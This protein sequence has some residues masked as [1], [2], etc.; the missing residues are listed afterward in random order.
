[1]R[2]SLPNPWRRD[3]SAQRTNHVLKGT[4]DP[5][6]KYHQG[7]PIT[8]NENKQRGQI[9]FVSSPDAAMWLSIKVC[10]SSKCWIGDTSHEVLNYEHWPC[11]WSVV[12][13]N[14]PFLFWLYQNVLTIISDANAES[15]AVVVVETC[16]RLVFLFCY[17]R[18][19]NM[20][21]HYLFFTG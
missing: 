8:I 6:R 13:T 5:N 19:S 9:V 18:N 12:T 21:V 15:G 20:L 17:I 2:P 11:W 7:K 14:N 10:R 16:N 3:D 1:M 4:E